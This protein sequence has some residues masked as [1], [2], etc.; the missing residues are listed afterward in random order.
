M[1]E[2]DVWGNTTNSFIF[3]VSS[4]FFLYPVNHSLKSFSFLYVFFMCVYVYLFYYEYG[5]VH[6]SIAIFNLQMIANFVYDSDILVL[7]V[8]LQVNSSLVG[9]Y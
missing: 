1:G 8:I 9:L 3:K 2:R 5:R 4:S 6:V 7:L